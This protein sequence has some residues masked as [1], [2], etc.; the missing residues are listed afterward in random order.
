MCPPTGAAVRGLPFLLRRREKRFEPVVIGE[1]FPIFTS[2][3]KDTLFR[4]LIERR[5]DGYA[6]DE[7][8]LDD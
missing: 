1:P 3:G 8:V 7:N 2:H 4:S 6:E 5:S